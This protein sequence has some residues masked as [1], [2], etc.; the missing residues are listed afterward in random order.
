ML[1]I[2]FLSFEVYS[3]TFPIECAEDGNLKSF[4]N[5]D[6]KFTFEEA[7]G[8]S[9]HNSLG[10][11]SEKSCTVDVGSEVVKLARA[12]SEFLKKNE[13][14][15]N[16]SEVVGLSNR[17][18]SCAAQASNLKI[19]YPFKGPNKLINSDN[20][21]RKR[22]ESLIRVALE[23]NVDPFLVLA[24]S[25]MESPH[26]INPNRKGGYTTNYGKIPIDGLPV[27]E[28]L[29]CI[30]KISK[31]NSIK[32]T[33][34]EIQN[35]YLELRNA[36]EL[37]KKNMGKEKLELLSRFQRQVRESTSSPYEEEQVLTKLAKVNKVDCLN[38]TEI[39][40]NILKAFC[41]NNKLQETVRFYPELSEK[42]SAFSQYRFTLPSKFRT[43][44]EIQYESDVGYLISP[45]KSI[46]T[47][48]LPGDISK[49]TLVCIPTGT[50]AHGQPSWLQVSNV[51][52][53]DL[54]DSCCAKVIGGVPSTD[55]PSQLLDLFSMNLIN[56]KV[57]PHSKISSDEISLEIQNY[58]GT[59]C[60]GCSEKTDNNCFTG[61]HMGSRPLY[62]ARVADLI[63]NSMMNNF[64]VLQIVKASSIKSD[65]KVKSIFCLARGK[66]L[67]TVDSQTYLN[68][69]KSFLLEGDKMELK[70]TNQT[71]QFRGKN[72]QLPKNPEG[73]ES[74]KQNES[75]RKIACAKFFK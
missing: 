50:L 11:I 52:D 58:N 6:K 61:L 32:S 28:N 47:F 22:I 49:S 25:T 59:G 75:K 57:N 13:E 45:P 4:E 33:P 3:S 41:N 30:E 5:D 60:M 27:A 35:K 46:K 63:I 15:K 44:L 18:K 19:S 70:T 51:E 10:C 17:T 54:K 53:S 72:G 71:L 65:K 38:I 43:E 69:Q 12:C 7:K 29:G 36:R 1:L 14:I 39:P 23:H 21:D 37:I 64:D 40:K 73:I 9:D 2:V 34:A 68:Q 8:V 20:Y 31:N 16:T 48:K 56:K 26:I 42:D 62:G 55:I 66:D 67:H 24:I 74:F